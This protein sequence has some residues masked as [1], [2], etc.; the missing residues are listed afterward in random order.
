MMVKESLCALRLSIGCRGRATRSI[1]PPAAARS[2]GGSKQSHR[3]R[4]D[5]QARWRQSVCV[6]ICEVLCAGAQPDLEHYTLLPVVGGS[7]LCDLARASGGLKIAMPKPFGLPGMPA[8]LRPCSS[9][10]GGLI[11]A[12]RALWFGCFLVC[13]FMGSFLVV[14]SS[15]LQA[16]GVAVA[17]GEPADPLHR[18]PL[19]PSGRC[20]HPQQL[21]TTI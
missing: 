5:W 7:A 19:C 16:V 13:F 8:L 6:S 12:G 14:H 2:Q 20:G 10:K 21:S 3:R 11:I 15:L 9:V 18:T 1:T 17:S 4:R